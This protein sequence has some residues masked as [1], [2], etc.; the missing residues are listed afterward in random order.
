MSGW[1]TDDGNIY[2][3]GEENEG[4]A[5]TGWQ[6]LEPDEDLGYDVDEAWFYFQSSG[7]AHKS[8]RKYINGK[9]YAFDEYGVMITDWQLGTVDGVATADIANPDDIGLKENQ[10]SFYDIDNGDQGSGWVYTY[11]DR[12]EDGDQKWFYLLSA[13]KNRVFN[14]N[15]VDSNGGSAIKYTNGSTVDSTKTKVAARVIKGKTYLFDNTGA[16]LTGVYEISVADVSRNSGTALKVGNIYYFNKSGGSVEGQMVTGKTTVTYDGDNFTYYFKEDG[17]AYTNVV[18]SDA[19]YD[20][21]GVRVE[22]GDGNAYAVRE[23]GD[24]DT[25]GAAGL[26]IGTETYTQGTI[27]VSSTGKAKKSGTI[28]IDGVK[29]VLNN[30]VVTKAYDKEDKTATD[31]KNFYTPAE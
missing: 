9:Y 21:Y 24:A 30:Y 12:D 7:K 27:I 20:K 2:Y 18:K 31:N 6:Y 14:S 28:T 8:A 22:A 16:L 17:S 23:I 29:Y 1:L 11:A 13:E 26:T 15:G 10:N 5:Y 25:F 4:W 3:L 19:A